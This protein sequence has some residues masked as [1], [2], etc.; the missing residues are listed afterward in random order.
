MT[1][2]APRPSEV[3]ARR[4]QSARQGQ[5]ISAAKLAERCAELGMPELNRDVI[6]NIESGRRHAVTVDELVTLG[7]ALNIPPV[8]LLF[9]IGDAPRVALT[10]NVA[11][12]VRLALEWFEGEAPLVG[13][14][15]YTHRAAPGA[16][17]WYVAAAPLHLYRELWWLQQNV[18]RATTDADQK[19]ALERLREHVEVTMRRAGF[20]ERELLAQYKGSDDDG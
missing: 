8:V 14:D 16:P 20:D 7:A 6:A 18:R 2:P 11:P 10:P 13:T 5:G 17:D 1:Q 3:V 9:P 4:V 15:G 19:A 12:R